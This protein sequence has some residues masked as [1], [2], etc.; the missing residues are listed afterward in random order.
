MDFSK[1]PA[2][3]FIKINI[4]EKLQNSLGSHTGVKNFTIPLFEF[5]VL[6]LGEKGTLTQVFQL[7]YFSGNPFLKLCF[8][9][10]GVAPQLVYFLYRRP[11]LL[12]IS[13]LSFIRTLALGYLLRHA[14]LKLLGRFL[15][16]LLVYRGNDVMRKIQNTLQAAGG[17]VKQQCHPV[18]YPLGKP[19]MAHRTCQFDMA[20]ALPAYL[21]PGYLNPALLTNNPL[22]AYPLVLT[23]IAFEVFGRAKDSLT[24][25]PVL[26]RL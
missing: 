25:E 18:R 12:H 23:A 14:L 1:Q 4:P 22:V 6:T 21:C 24:E 17:D 2:A 11:I 3:H 19:D 16:S 7:F 9:L 5:V 10:Q 20:H 15:A 13:N 8:L 26:L